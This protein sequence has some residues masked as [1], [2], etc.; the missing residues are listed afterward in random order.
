VLVG[1]LYSLIA[2]KIKAKLDTFEVG[3]SK[4]KR[5]DSF[6]IG[7]EDDK[8]AL[9]QLQR[10]YPDRLFVRPENRLSLVDSHS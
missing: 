8:M 5:L 1:Q 7:R 10:L 2:I 6:A 9:V 3:T 4:P